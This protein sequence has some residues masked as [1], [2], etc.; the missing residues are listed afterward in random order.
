MMVAAAPYKKLSDVHFSSLPAPC[1]TELG[2]VDLIGRITRLRK[3]APSLTAVRAG[4][5]TTAVA[6]RRRTDPDEHLDVA[7]GAQIARHFRPGG[8]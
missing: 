7:P 1:E 2:N 3:G 6:A 4:A 8:W 5:I